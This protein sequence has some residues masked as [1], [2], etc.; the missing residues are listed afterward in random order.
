MVKIYLMT[1]RNNSNYSYDEDVC[2][3]DGNS[4]GGNSSDDEDVCCICLDSFVNNGAVVYTV[5]SHRFHRS[6]ITGCFDHDGR[7]PLCRSNIAGHQ[8]LNS[9]PTRMGCIPSSFTGDNNLS[10]NNR[11]D[12][13]NINNI[14]YHDGDERHAHE[15]NGESDE[16]RMRYETNRNRD[17][18]S[19][20]DRNWN[21][22]FGEQDNSARII[23][24]LIV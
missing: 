5:C 6:C 16:P 24:A 7:C 8:L 4:Y 1:I 3:S 22:Y 20:T 19:H 18:I 2:Y 17:V 21:H 23:F 10:N 12:N 15:E 11:S 9:P 13:N 14:I